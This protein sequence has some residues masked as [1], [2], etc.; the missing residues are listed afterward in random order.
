VNAHAIGLHLREQST[1]LELKGRRAVTLQVGP[2]GLADAVLRHDPPT[3]AELERA[4]DLVEDALA[5]LHLKVAGDDRLVTA[6]AL[7]LALPGLGAHSG[8]LTR[9]EVE[10]LFQRLASRSLGTP[11]AAAELPPGREI[12]AAL[13]ILRECMHHLGFDRVDAIPG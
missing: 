3:P 6:D 8:G 12:A 1:L 7:L 10:F 13:L 2:Q 4:I 9:D 5:G 11:I